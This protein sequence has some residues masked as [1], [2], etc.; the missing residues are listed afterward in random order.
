MESGAGKRKDG[1]EA[2][3]RRNGWQPT[4]AEVADAPGTF[5]SRFQ[6]HRRV[7]LEAKKK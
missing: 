4:Y 2:H 1:M 6:T 7:G 5:W 3:K